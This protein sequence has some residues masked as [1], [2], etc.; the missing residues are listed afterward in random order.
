MWKLIQSICI[1]IF[2]AGIGLLSCFSLF[3]H[4]SQAS[5][6]VW[7]IVPSGE[8]TGPYPACDQVL[9]SIQAAVNSAVD[10]DEIWVSSGTYT[11]VHTSHP[12]SDLK[13]IV[14]FTKSLTIRGG[15]L[16]PF[17]EPPNFTNNPT[18][19]DAQGQAG[20]LH[21]DSPDAT[22]EGLHI[23]GGHIDGAGV[24]IYYGSATLISNKIYENGKDGGGNGVIIKNSRAILRQNLVQNNGGNIDYG[25]GIIIADSHVTLT[26]N[27]IL[28]NTADA[29]TEEATM[30]GGIYANNSNLTMTNN[31][32]EGNTAAGITSAPAFGGGLYLQDSVINL[33]GNRIHGN[34]A[35]M[36]ATDTIDGSCYDCFGW[37]GG[38]FLDNTNGTI[39]GNELV[40]NK[41]I[42]TNGLSGNGGGLF[43]IG[44]QNLTITNNLFQGNIALGKSSRSYSEGIGGGFNLHVLG[45]SG[46]TPP[47]TTILMANNT[48]QDNKGAATG[49]LGLGG[50]GVIYGDDWQNNDSNV[51]F[52]FID[53]EVVRNSGLI[54]GRDGIGGGLYVGYDEDDLV[55]NIFLEQNK[56]IS[57]TAAV[58][59]SKLGMG[60]GLH[61]Y[62]QNQIYQNNLIMENVATENGPGYGGGIS[63]DGRSELL[64]VNTVLNDNEASAG[65]AALYADGQNS[66]IMM[67]H[68]TIAR[69]ENPDGLA[70]LLAE[71]SYDDAPAFNN[72][73]EMTNTILV[74]YTT[75][76]SV[77][78][79]HT[80]SLNSTLWHNTSIP[81]I[82]GIT[83]T[84]TRENKYIG[85]PAFAADGYHIS[86]D[87][88]AARRGV[89]TEIHFDIDHEKR[90]FTP[91][92]GADEYWA[93]KSYLPF[94]HKD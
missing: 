70:I 68:T 57:N 90:P 18:I 63:V 73:L 28:S 7:C 5:G 67:Q 51:T 62:G 59:A 50:G 55:D 85:D 1:S 83:A 21:L 65:G 54:S 20:V 40:G 79:G 71:K 74:S 8:A 92:L 26:E 16:P 88:A 48:I 35:I 25:G 6:G 31:L 36:T 41:A 60:G 46:N 43:I 15:Y 87:S 61:L 3:T 24:E 84:V 37:G 78:S 91:T 22:I 66:H 76:I 52:L 93:H 53:N 69:Q 49:T 33:R 45:F 11:D 12:Y 19:L 14:F 9:T 94:A 80:V 34:T 75:G 56:I 17:S 81:I 89:S 10:G 39:D 72:T 82:A 13:Y 4:N 47:P 42:A 77:S 38:L 44:Q 58:T 86:A 30:G 29:F 32:V 23:T 64:F 2:L 27:Q